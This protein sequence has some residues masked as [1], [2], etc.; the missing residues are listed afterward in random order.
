MA[1]TPLPPFDRGAL[2]R[3]LAERS[4]AENVAIGEPALLP[5]GAI[6]ENWGFAAQFTGGRLAG[7]QALVL[8][9]DA[10]TGIAA[11]LGRIEEFAVLQ[12][13]CAAGIS[14][15]ETIE[16][17]SNLIQRYAEGYSG[18]RRVYPALKGIHG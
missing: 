17:K 2:A 16:P 9:A 15:A 4:G 5:G 1:A 18:Y 11:S 10:P 14:V 7:G 3:F 8:R 13:A 6:K 12:A